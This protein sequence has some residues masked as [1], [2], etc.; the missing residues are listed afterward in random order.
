[1]DL[2]I[3][4][5]GIF[6]L[7]LLVV[8]AFFSMSET[9]ITAASK[10]KLHFLSKK[11]SK[12]ASIVQRLQEDM[13][14]VIGTLLM[15]NTLVNVLLS[16]LATGIFY[17][18]FGE[19][20][21]VY[22]ALIMGTLIVIYAEVM[23]K[24]YAINNAEKVSLATS[25]LVQKI[26]DFCLPLTTAVDFIARKSLLLLNA[27]LVQ[28]PDHNQQEDELRG[29]IELHAIHNEKTE[30]MA[31]E[32]AMLHSIL[33]LNS[34]NVSKIMTHRRSVVMLDAAHDPR[35]L[36]HNILSCSYTRI[37]LWRDNP[38]NIIGVIHSKTVLRA[39][40]T[41]RN[42]LNNI[43]I[44]SLANQPWFILESTSL[45]DQ[46]QAFRQRR[47]HFAVVVDE[48][49]A[50][51]GIVTLED[52]LEEIVGEIIDEYDISTDGIRPQNDGSYL[53]DGIVPIRDLNRR[54]NWDLPADEEAST[55][56]GLV[57]Y[58]TRHIPEIGQTFMLHGFRFE[59][60]QRKRNQVTLL[61]LTPPVHL[62]K[63]EV[64]RINS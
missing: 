48:Y 55:I 17:E 62:R 51:M 41:Y 10:A 33:D 38:E 64:T 14:R 60:I 45:Y 34:V 21:V 1:M 13:G 61:R 42:S 25:K 44:I 35:K 7:L 30:E 6:L 23:P 24:I 29:A 37:P 63:A 31:Q 3:W 8:A 11:G 47:E 32:K 19:A 39:L 12:E 28:K 52:I 22:S 50:F 40:Y 26:V 18:I 9:A 4:V 58:E 2:S 49:G 57:I 56:A 36:I 20:G 53:I 5:S 59:V 43:D 27:N 16:S 54:F 15:G 46:L